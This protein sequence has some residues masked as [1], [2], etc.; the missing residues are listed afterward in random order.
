MIPLKVAQ[1]MG[2]MHVASNFVFWL[3]EDYPCDRSIGGPPI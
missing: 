3:G 2:R 1:E